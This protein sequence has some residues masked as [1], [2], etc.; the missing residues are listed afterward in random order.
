M[1]QV[2][3][4]TGVASDRTRPLILG[5]LLVSGAS[6]LIYEILWMKMLTLVIGNTVFS[7]TTV[8][9]AFMGGLALGSYLAGRLSGR[10]TDPLRTYGVLEA[11]IGAYALLVPLLLAGTEPLFRVVYQTL[12]PSFYTLSLLRFVVCGLLLLIPTTLMGATLP[13]LAKHFVARTS[14]VGWNVGLLYGVNTFGAVLG[15]FA[16]GFVLIPRVGVT[17][18]IVLAALLNLSVAGGVMLVA[19]RRAARA[20]AGDAPCGDRARPGK[21]SK[22]TRERETTP[23]EAVVAAEAAEA[24]G[25]SRLGV[26]VLVGIGLSGVAA[27]TYQI[28]WTRVLSLSIGSSVY[29][30]SLILTA[31]IGGLALGSLLIAGLLDRRRHLVVGLG[32]TQGAIALSALLMVPLLGALP[33][34]VAETVLDGARSFQ[35]ILGVEFAVVFGLVLVPTALMGA[36]VP[37]A[38]TVCT[39]EVARV[40]RSVGTVYAVNTGGAI[41]GSVATGFLLIPWLGTQT[42]ILIAVA[43]NVVAAGLLLLHAP[44]VPLHRRVAG[45][46]VTATLVGLAWYPTAD[47]DEPILNSGA[48]L[49]AAVYKETAAEE[50]ID[51]AAAMKRGRDV[52]FFEEG[53]HAAVSVQQ[54]AAGALWLSVN[55]KTDATARG[56]RRHPTDA[57]PSPAAAASRSHR[58]AGDRPRE[59]DDVGRGGTASGDRCRRGRDRSGRRRGQPLLRRRDRCPARRSPRQPHRR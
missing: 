38:V 40:G 55:G 10:I 41:V 6:G 15:S 19:R 13:V 3:R 29:A 42:S 49:Y 20:P 12:A 26:V 22:K 23:V 48:F 8:L 45:T 46:V 32:L 31:F 27:M 17:W 54:S 59:R 16:A 1:K 34:F 14:H 18:T 39:A 33:V 50:D 4:K 7:V 47:W 11:A 30:F 44:R 58:G 21:K 5:F 35:T 36:A 25:S 2:A 53:L 56:G 24:A 51:V 9:T 28:A 57:G 37:M 43:L 52:L